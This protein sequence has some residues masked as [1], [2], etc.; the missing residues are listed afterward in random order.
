MNL[1]ILF[2]IPLPAGHVTALSL[3][4]WRHSGQFVNAM[5]PPFYS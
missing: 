1:Q 4:S 3:T 5:P 2:M